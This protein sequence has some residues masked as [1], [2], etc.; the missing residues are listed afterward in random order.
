MKLATLRDGSEEGR[1]LVVS[2][3]LSRAIDAG[4]IAPTLLAALRQWD[5]VETPLRHLAD[6]LETGLLPGVPFDPARAM[7]PLPRAPQWLD[8]SCFLNHGRLMAKAF[9]LDK[10]VDTDIPLVYQGA[11]DDFLG[12]QDDSP[13]PSEADGI[14]FEGEFAVITGPVPMGTRAADAERH[15]RLI[16]MV[17]DVSLRIFGPREMQGGFGFIQAK[18]S[19]G[20]APVA[21]TPDEL[22]DD[23][24]D[25]RVHLPLHVFWNGARFGHPHG[26]EMDFGFHRLIEHVSRTR[27]L[28]AG[29]IIG[30][31]TISN[32]D[33]E[34]GSACIAE[35]RAMEMIAGRPLTPYMR[36]GDRVRMTALA[37]DGTAPFGS[38]DQ[39]MV[40]G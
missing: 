28:S 16:T 40:A 10:G 3:D 31:G 1:L 4:T 18:P 14:D 7:A 35:R 33:P 39:R 37:P 23:W 17:N 9:K 25:G 38:I 36:F 34:V 22:G 15:I 19:T 30:S 27:K 5:T 11:S 2:R 13:L 12:P 6:A 8:G 29:T 32:A 21:I 26:G 24:R 20:F